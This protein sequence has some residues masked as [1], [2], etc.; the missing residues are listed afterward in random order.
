MTS[1]AVERETIADRVVAAYRSLNER[2]LDDFGDLYD[3]QVITVNP[4]LG[5]PI[6]VQSVL[7]EYRALLVAFPDLHVTVDEV[8]ET[9]DRIV[10]RLNVGGTHTGQWGRHAPTHNIVHIEI[11]EVAEC[12]DGRLI[13]RQLYWDRYTV[14]QQLGLC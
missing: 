12:C 13:T 7:A 4:S 10:T 14:M 11:C 9:G 1:P 8:I 5:N 3:A 2:R 6:G